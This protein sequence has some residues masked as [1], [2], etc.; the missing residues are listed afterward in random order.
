MECIHL[1]IENELT[2]PLDLSYYSNFTKID[3]YGNDS[4]NGLNNITNDDNIK[5]VSFIDVENGIKETHDDVM[6]HTG[7]VEAAIKKGV[8]E[9]RLAYSSRLPNPVEGVIKNGIKKTEDGFSLHDYKVDEVIQNGIKEVQPLPSQEGNKD[10]GNYYS[11][12]EDRTKPHTKYVDD[13]I[14]KG[15]LCDWYGKEVSYN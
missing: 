6:P 8:K 4:I 3:I 5:I 11:R 9:T 7:R 2:F 1:T 13:V 14:K 10:W 12:Q 15:Y